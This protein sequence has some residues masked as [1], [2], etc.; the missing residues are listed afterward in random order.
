MTS[1]TPALV[2]I[3]RRFSARPERVFDAF[4]DPTLAGQFMF[5][6]PAGEMTKVEIDPR[7]GGSF[8]FVDRRAGRDVGHYGTYLEIDRPRRLVFSFTVDGIASDP[9]RVTIEIAPVDMGCELTLTHEMKPEWAAY[10]DRTE[11]GWGMILQGL[12]TAI[13][14]TG[15]QTG[16]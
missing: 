15:N 16:L 14:R 6:T 2:C 7:V 3:T 5:A 13:S 1:S 10:V 9:D 4:L 12:E 8:T 11:A